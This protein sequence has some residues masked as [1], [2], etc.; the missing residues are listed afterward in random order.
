MNDEGE[1]KNLT[2]DGG[3]DEDLG[4]G[5]DSAVG[6]SDGDVECGWEV[7]EVVVSVSQLKSVFDDGLGGC[8][9]V[10]KVE[11]GDF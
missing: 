9:S 8:S 7:L 1:D 3:V 4:I 11:D 10:D 5:E 2:W 6:V